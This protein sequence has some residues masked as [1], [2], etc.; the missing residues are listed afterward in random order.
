MMSAE[1]NSK[2][3]ASYQKKDWRGHA[4]PPFYWYDNDKDLPY[5]RDML[6]VTDSFVISYH[7]NNTCMPFVYRKFSN[8]GAGHRYKAKGAP[9]FRHS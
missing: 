3:L 4:H 5:S 1:S 6:Q 8:K 9:Y 7:S 2:K